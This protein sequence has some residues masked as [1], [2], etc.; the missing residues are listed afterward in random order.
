MSLIEDWVRHAD[1][2]ENFTPILNVTFLTSILVIVALAVMIFLEVIKKMPT[3]LTQDAG[4]SKMII[5]SLVVGVIAILFVTFFR[6]ILLYGDVLYYASKLELVEEGYT[7]T[8]YNHNLKSLN[9]MWLIIY[10]VSF[11]A[12]LTAINQLFIKSKSLG[13]VTFIINC[14]VTFAFLSIGLYQLSELRHDYLRQSDGAYY[15]ITNWNLMIRYLALVFF[16]SL[17]FL[18]YRYS[19]LKAFEMN[20]STFID[21]M[22]SGIILWLFTSELIHWLDIYV[23]EKA[24]KLGVSILWGVFSLACVGIGIFKRKA[25]LRIGAIVIFVITLGK[26]FFYDIAHLGYIQKTIVFVVLGILLLIISFLYNKFKDRIA[27]EK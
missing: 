24:Y 21:L 7:L 3:S 26:L 12:V 1:R 6:E 27:D 13:Y 17:T 20:L 9:Q 10:T 16:A 23:P 4:S 5:R 2:L 18:Q 8:K 25:H 14:I 19:K 22:L 11:F 15:I